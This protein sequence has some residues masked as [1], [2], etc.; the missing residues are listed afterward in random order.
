MNC[1]NQIILEGNLIRDVEVK[2]LVTGS[3][4]AQFTVA[5]NRTYKKSDGETAIEVSYFDIKAYGVM[6]ESLADKLKKGRGVRVVGRLKQER[7]N[8]DS[9]RAYSRVFVVAEHIEIKPFTE[10]EG[11]K[12]L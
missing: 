10:K 5:V 12:Y 11:E 6:A 1:L 3:K 8:D 9:G 7:G 4:F 2:D